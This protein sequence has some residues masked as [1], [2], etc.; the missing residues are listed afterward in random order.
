[1]RPFPRLL[2]VLTLTHGLVDTFAAFVQ[3]L[4][5][6]LQ[7]QLSLDEGSIQW[8]Y[9]LWG[10]ASSVS[11]L[12]FGYWGD[13]DRGRMMLWL[14]PVVGVICLSAIGLVHS[15]VAL[16]LLLIAGGLGIAAFHPE[17]AALAGSSAP[18]HRSRAMSIFAVGGYLGQ[19]AGPFYSG[20]ITTSFG[21]R[22]LVWSITWGLPILALLLLGMG[23]ASAQKATP[24]GPT[25]SVSLASLIRGRRKAVTA[26]LFVGVFRVLPT[27]G[28]PIALAYLL[29]GRGSSNED[30]GIVQSV[31]LG[32]IGAG[33]LACA[34]FV[35]RTNERKVLTLLPWLA[36]PCLLAS[37][38]V[39]FGLMV[40]CSAA[41]GLLLGATL[42][43]LVSYGQKLMPEGQ[44]VASSI[45]MG[46][47]YGIGGVIVAL[48]MV[49]VNHAHRPDHA[50]LAFAGSCILS[51]LLC[52][53]L[54]EP[55]LN[56]RPG[57]LASA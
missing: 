11:Q 9:V 26:I 32:A 29:K 43:I 41:T 10:L 5:P 28:V 15:L 49:S 1:M 7:V 57:A 51:S 55:E 42:P 34:A 18:D 35:R 56:R 23:G 27:M 52:Y 50:F 20:T 48:L 16:N 31:F 17:A 40:A 33:G 46:V 25:A 37:P 12:L 53:W 30:I 13:R 45:T 14:G 21:L 47:T 3:P 36:A 22:A 4:W 38:V 6:D 2:L 24:K 39:G 44:R 8:A 54:P 19:A